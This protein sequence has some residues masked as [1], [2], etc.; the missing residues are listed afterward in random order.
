MQTVADMRGVGDEYG[1]KVFQR[2]LGTYDDKALFMDI[3]ISYKKKA[4]DLCFQ[5]HI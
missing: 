2:Q 5:N 1:R 4:S 3:E